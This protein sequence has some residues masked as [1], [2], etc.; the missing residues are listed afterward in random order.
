[1]KKKALFLILIYCICSPIFA[2]DEVGQYDNRSRYYE[3]KDCLYAN[4]VDP[5]INKNIILE[6]LVL[7]ELES[8]DQVFLI[9]EENY[10]KEIRKIIKESIKKASKFLPELK[11]QFNNDVEVSIELSNKF[12]LYFTKSYMKKYKLNKCSLSKDHIL[13]FDYLFF[14]EST[15]DIISTFECK[16]NNNNILFSRRD[17]YLTFSLLFKMAILKYESHL[18]KYVTDDILQGFLEVFPEH[19]IIQE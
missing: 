12:E 11:K 3:H 16:L 2:Q 15:N 19:P 7:K 18:S 17:T 9:I 13:V 5:V 6:K 4:I 8:E 1:M 14:I 10:K